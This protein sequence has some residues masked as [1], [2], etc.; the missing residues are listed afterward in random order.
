MN[1]SRLFE[2]FTSKVFSYLS[3]FNISLYNDPI[4]LGLSG[5]KDSTTLLLTLKSLGFQVIPA[6]ID[7]GYPNF[8]V[9]QMTEYYESIGFVPLVIS[10][11]DAISHNSKQT[12]TRFIRH[13][14]GLLQSEFSTPCG[15]CSQI[16]RSL[17]IRE[18]NNRGIKW[19][20]LGHH[21]ED[22]VVTMLKDYFITLYYYSIG[23]YSMKRFMAFVKTKAIDK[24]ILKSLIAK[25]LASSMSLKLR[26]DFRTHLI[27]PFA[28]VTEFSIIRFI[29]HN[30]ISTFGSGC[31]H[32]IFSS[33]PMFLTKREIVHLEYL[34][35]LKKNPNI[36]NEL[37]AL[38][39]T[40]L[41]TDG[42]AKFNPRAMRAKHLPNLE[43]IRSTAN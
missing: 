17:L 38:A 3:D 27:R 6:I 32:G 42:S 18:A 43:P 4:L 30:G 2:L 9:S 39:M 35:R 40:T 1:S 15:P 13:N 10:V 5:G 23:T 33:N 26:L 20:A 25:E 29:K 8:P 21:R 12:S 19:I 14:L 34:E 24:H 41:N 28:Y 22:I 7:I 31:A 16:K 36:G 37:L 11:E